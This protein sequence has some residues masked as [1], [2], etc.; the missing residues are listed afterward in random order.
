MLTMWSVYLCRFKLRDYF[1]V[2]QRCMIAIQHVLSFV[3]TTDQVLKPAAHIANETV[4]HYY[5]QNQH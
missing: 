1:L 4:G 3:L 5:T 2:T